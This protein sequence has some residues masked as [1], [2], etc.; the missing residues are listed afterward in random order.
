M[1][2]DLFFSPSRVSTSYLSEKGWLPSTL[3]N[4]LTVQPLLPNSTEKGSK[5][6]TTATTLTS[7]SPLSV[8]FLLYKQSNPGLAESKQQPDSSINALYFNHGFGASSLSWLPAIPS[9][10]N[11][12]N[13]KIGIAH[14]AP[15]MCNLTIVPFSKFRLIILMMETLSFFIP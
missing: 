1:I 8:H 15:G 11:N 12:L 10:V 4:I 2:Q 14:D 3:S 9:L 13:A 7:P 5:T 6:K